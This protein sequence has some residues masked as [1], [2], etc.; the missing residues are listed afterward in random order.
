AVWVRLRFRYAQAT[1]DTLRPDGLR[2]AAPRVARQGEAWRPGLDLNQ[3][4]EHCT[5]PASTLPPP[6]RSDHRRSRRG[7]PHLPRRTVNNSR[8][9]LINSAGARAVPRRSFATDCAR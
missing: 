5:A 9:L 4:K 6:G 8:R 7:E 1:P 2:V 3:D